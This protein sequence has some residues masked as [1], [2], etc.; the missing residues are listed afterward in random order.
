MATRNNWLNT[1]SIGVA[2]LVVAGPAFA[3][4]TTVPPAPGNLKLPSITFSVGAGAM[5]G[6]PAT[7]ATG[8][9][10]LDRHLVLEGS[11]GRWERTE[12]YFS[13]GS[14]ISTSM[15]P[16]YT[17]DWRMTTD[18]TG[19]SAGANVLYRYDHGRIS[20]FGGG[21]LGYSNILWH[22]SSIRE[23]CTLP[24]GSGYTCSDFNYS[25]NERGWGLQGTT[26]VDVRVAGPVI[27]YGS[28]NVTPY[29]G[30]LWS[31]GL[32]V[33]ARSVDVTR[34]DQIRAE[35]M[36]RNSAPGVPADRAIG[37]NVRVTFM[38]GAQMRGTLLTL[39]KT[40]VVVRGRSFEERYRTADVRLVETTHR[41]AV[42]GMLYGVLAGAVVGV[43][44]SVGCEDE[45]GYCAIV[46]GPAIGAVGAA[47][48]AGIGGLVDRMSAPAHI[49]YSSATPPVQLVP[50]AVNK[51]GG[52]G[53][54]V[55]W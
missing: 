18:R 53:M 34:V 5:S 9:Y 15:G 49:V 10:A 39:N 52:I 4:T 17:G 11:F 54:R 22:E 6:G 38:N 7:V 1:F 26:G 16:G 32:R 35:R 8:R 42:K 46:F 19:W 31:A 25:W 2:A 43:V 33:A 29:A 55:R 24:S 20:W 40:E 44:S 48:G 36:A 12:S 14:Q 41:K 21:G 45:F 27:A 51:G 37:T 3:Q 50:I 28:V 47:V 30:V 23:G 13:P